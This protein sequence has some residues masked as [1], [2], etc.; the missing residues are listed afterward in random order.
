MRNVFA[1]VCQ[2]GFFFSNG[3]FKNNFCRLSQWSTGFL[4]RCLAKGIDEIT[5]HLKI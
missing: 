1:A 3:L 5:F 2:N 4:A